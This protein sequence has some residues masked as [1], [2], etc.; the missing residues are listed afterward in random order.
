MSQ[1]IADDG[2]TIYLKISG[3]GPP[4]IMLHGWTSDHREWFP[5]LH[6]LE[7]HRRIYRW[8]ARAHGGHLPQ[9]KSL[10]NVQRMAHDLANLLDHYAL[11]EVDVVGHSMGALT[12][13][14]Y[15]RDFGLKRIRR[16]CFIDQSPKLLTDLHWPYGIYGDFDQAKA[17]RFEQRL[18]ED[19]AEAVLELIAFGLNEH[20]R[21]KYLENSIGWQKSRSALQTMRP[22][23]LIACWRSLT[24]ADYRDI[25]PV[26]DR[27][28]L[29][30]Y[31]SHSNFYHPEVAHYVA[32]HLPNAKLQVY[33]NT[34]HSPHMWKRERFVQDLLAFLSS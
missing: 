18:Q 23:P 12:L 11:T 29:L 13:W 7:P 6:G 30:I 25:L 10:P 14:Q 28:V 9:T 26:I 21:T 33:E 3:D 19:F 27:P 34:D 20:A 24:E 22:D 31:G 1:F 4:L 15:C 5:F 17:Q 2:E 16:A 8:D 32:S